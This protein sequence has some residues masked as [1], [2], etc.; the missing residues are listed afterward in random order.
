MPI[1]KYCDRRLPEPAAAG[2]LPP[3]LPGGAARPHEGD[4]PPRSEAVERAGGPLR[5]RA[6]P[7]GHRLRRGQGDRAEADRADDVHAGRPARRHAAVHEPRA[8]RVQRSG[9]RHPQRHLFPGRAPVRTLD[10]LDAVR[11]EGLGRGRVRRD[12]ADHSRGRAAEA[13]PAALDDGGAGEASPPT[14]G[15]SRPSWA[16]WSRA[17]STGS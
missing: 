17:T 12:P 11:A 1:T 10:R 4:H 8:G 15:R 14:A 16:G 7:Q 6:G 9:H 5:R 3:G 13:E 2:A